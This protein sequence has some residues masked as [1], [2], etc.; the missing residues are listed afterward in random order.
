MLPVWCMFNMSSFE[1]R[2]LYTQVDPLSILL[3][4]CACCSL[5]VLWL[6]KRDALK[7]F[8]LSKNKGTKDREHKTYFTH[9]L[10][11]ITQIKL[12][13]LFFFPFEMQAEIVLKQSKEIVRNGLLL[14]FLSM[15]D[16]RGFVHEC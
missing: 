6:T 15:F 7:I 13:K 16:S 11:A 14:L 8:C 4:G 10:W 2:I 9:F 3:W 5:T 1:T 12:G